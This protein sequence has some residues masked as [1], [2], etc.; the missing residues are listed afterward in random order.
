MKVN[1][2]ELW[3]RNHPWAPLYA[4]ALGRPPLAVAG[5]R[6][7][8]NTDM[9]LL[10]RAIDEI[11]Q[12]PPG[13]AVLDVPCGGGVA[14]RGIRQG[15]DLRYV[16]SDI[17]EAM[18]ERTAA[19]AE[20]LGVQVE[21]QQAD[22]AALPFQEGEFDLVVSFTGLHCFPD[23][24][25]AVQEIARVT[26]TGG[27]VS[28]SFVVSDPKPVY[29]PVLAVGR[30]AGLLGPSC[31]ADEVRRWLTETDFGGIEIQTSGPMAYFRAEKATAP[32]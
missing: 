17:A 18:L 9:R 14:L 5:G 10:Y 27:R 29:K 11:G 4:F 15:Q 3:R 20:R 21:L 1:P 24:H 13:S 22:I 26:R 2:S 8:M 28:G 31:T 32:T 7:L 25:A 23:P 12:L 16:A 19:E 6:V 30:A